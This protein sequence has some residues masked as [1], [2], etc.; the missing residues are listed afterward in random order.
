MV[1]IRVQSTTRRIGR[2]RTA[3]TESTDALPLADDRHGT[4]GSC[5]P[6]HEHP[7]DLVPAWHT[8]SGVAKIGQDREDPAV[9]V[10]S[11]VEPEFDED[12]AD[13][14]LDSLG[15]QDEQFRNRAV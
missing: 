4:H 10:G 13:M 11:F 3:G 7:L 6:R 14:R 9:I 2:M 15:T 8:N 1:Q 5:R 12:L